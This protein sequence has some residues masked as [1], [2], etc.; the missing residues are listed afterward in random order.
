MNVQSFTIFTIL[1][2]SRISEVNKAASN[3]RIQHPCVKVIRLLQIK[4]QINKIVC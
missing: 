3:V 1:I 2:M 4:G